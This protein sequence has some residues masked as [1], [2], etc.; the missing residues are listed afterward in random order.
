MSKAL[1]HL[2]IEE[3]RLQP[4]QEWPV[5]PGSWRFARVQGGAAY[6]LGEHRTRSL[7]GGELIVLSPKIQGS[8]RASQINEV[9]LHTFSFLPDLL[10]GFF[11]LAERHYFETTCAVSFAEAEFFPSTHL[12]ARQFAG[13]IVDPEEP[14]SLAR[15]AELLGLVVSIFSGGMARHRPPVT[16]QMS[17]QHRFHELI[18]K[19]P[20]TELIN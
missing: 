10:C 14:P 15:R 7:A 20:D 5:A 19:M 12:A 1:G 2:Q 8:I 13:L 16:R 6:W 9:V 11:T 3:L 4:G 17:A 18:S